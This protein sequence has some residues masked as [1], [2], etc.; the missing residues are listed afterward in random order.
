L[1]ASGVTLALL[2]AC[3]QSGRPLSD[4]T[5][6]PAFTG[7]APQLGVVDGNSYIVAPGDTVGAIAE[8]TNTP[9]RSLIDLN[10]LVPPYRLQSGTRLLLQP[11]SNYVVRQ[12]DT[13]QKVAQSQG[14]SQSALIQLNNLTAPYTLR[15]GQSLVLPSG[16]EASKAP[17]N[18]ALGQSFVMPQATPDG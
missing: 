17:T 8:R 1:A 18:V 5:A 14:V 15:P 4:G 12:G 10:H 2:T 16:I 11:R 3:N 7:V 6:G 9:V 13:I